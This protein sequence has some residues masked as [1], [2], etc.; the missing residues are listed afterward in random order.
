MFRLDIHTNIR[1]VRLL[2]TPSLDILNP[3]NKSCELSFRHHKNTK[4]WLIHS[5]YG[6]RLAYHRCVRTILVNGTP[7]CKRTCMRSTRFMQMYWDTPFSTST[8]ST[9]NFS[10]LTHL[11]IGQSSTRQYRCIFAV[12][13]ITVS[14]GL[15]LSSVVMDDIEWFSL[16]G[17]IFFIKFVFKFEFNHCSWTSLS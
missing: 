13:P 14:T 9:T 16:I 12:N 6:N 11:V 15:A 17:Q 1:Y 5:H 3:L 8:N 2:C 4:I 7:M 10:W